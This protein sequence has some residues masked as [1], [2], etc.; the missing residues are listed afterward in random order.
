MT[1]ELVVT[2]PPGA[3]ALAF[4]LAARAAG[5]D[6]LEVRTDLHDVGEV[7]LERLHAIVPLLVA[8]RN[9][10]VVP[11]L[12]KG[13]WLDEP[14]GGGPAHLASHHAATAMLPAEVLALWT[15]A[16]VDTAAHIKHVEPMGSHTT[17][18]RLVETQRLLV[19]AF[20]AHRVTVLCTGEAAIPWRCILSEKNALDYVAFS[21]SWRAAPGQR[22]LQDARR[23]RG[24]SGPRLGILGNSIASS[25]SPRIHPQPFDRLDLPP[26]TNVGALLEALRPFYRGLAV[27]SPFKRPVAQAVGSTLP[28]VNTLWMGWKSANTD[29]AGAR[30][31]LSHIPP[32]PLTVLGDGGV[33]DALRAAAQV[34]T[35]HVVRRCNAGVSLTGTVVWTWPPHVAPP[36]GLRLD[37]ARVVL[38]AYGPPA[39]RLAGMVRLLG[40][41]PWMAGPMWLVAQAREQRR[42]WLEAE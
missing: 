32:G 22:L 24:H 29:V 20:G 36:A 31:L 28:A 33:T 8:R 30:K 2:L 38:V 37:G 18:A 42:L 19:H 26:S 17:A 4:A 27:T 10:A 41:I 15:N 7:A 6:R 23:S 11:T 35:L 25:R 3:D 34:H 12:P 9:D 21:P 5:A 1:P 16:S 40:G 13:A 39:W 14:L